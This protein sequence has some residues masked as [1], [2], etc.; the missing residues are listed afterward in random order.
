[1]HK[2]A[3]SITRLVLYTPF[4]HSFRTAMY[5]NVVNEPLIFLP[6]WH[7][8]TRYFVNFHS[9]K[10]YNLKIWIIRKNFRNMQPDIWV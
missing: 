3:G 8:N 9:I 5:Q 7:Q 1:M 4:L 6:L 10:N 2:Q